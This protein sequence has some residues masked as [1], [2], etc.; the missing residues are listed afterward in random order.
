MTIEGWFDDKKRWY[1]DKKGLFADLIFG[2]LLGAT[3][4]SIP[5]SDTTVQRKSFPPELLQKSKN[6]K[7]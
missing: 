5:L 4:D 3:E 2:S 1:D 6:E 7:V